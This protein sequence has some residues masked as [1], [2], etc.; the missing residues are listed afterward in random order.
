MTLYSQ[1]DHERF[2][3][4]SV[5]MMRDGLEKLL[6]LQQSAQTTVE[7]EKVVKDDILK[8]TDQISSDLKTFAGTLDRLEQLQRYRQVEDEN[9][10]R[11]V[12]EVVNTLLKQLNSEMT[13][14]RLDGSP[15]V[16]ETLTKRRSS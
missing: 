14:G 5:A 16:Y 10:R 9:R 15:L 4:D 3:Q 1:E 12:E 7:N 8:I 2:T 11:V 6:K 13:L